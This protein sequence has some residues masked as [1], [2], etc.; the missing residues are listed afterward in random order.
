MRKLGVALLVSFLFIVGGASGALADSTSDYNKKVADAK[1]V[2]ATVEANL[3]NAKQVLENLKASSAT[4]S[5]LL[6]D[7][8]TAVFNADQALQSARETYLSKR[9]LYDAAVVAE[10]NAVDAVNLAVDAVAVAADAVDSSYQTY[11]EASQA[12][13]SADSELTTAQWNYD[14][15][16]ITSG[17][18]QTTPGLR[19]EVYTGVDSLG[20]P[21]QRSQSAYT[22]CKT[23]TVTQIDFNVGGGSVAGCGNDFVMIH[24]TGYITYPTAKSV[25]FYAQADDGF[26]LTINGQPI[27]ND[28]SLKGCGGNSA[29]LFTFQAGVSYP[30]DAW[31]YEWGGGAC[32][33]LFHQPAGSGVWSITPASM[34]TQQAVAVSTKDPALKLILDQKTAA[35]VSAV[36]VEETAYDAYLVAESVYDNAV[37]DYESKLA[38]L[39][40]KR[41][42]LVSAET[43]MNDS[44]NVWQSASDAYID[45]DAVLTNRKNQ[46]KVVFDQ[47]Q[48]QALVID[49]L[50]ND[51]VTAKANLAAIPKPVAPNKVTKKTVSKP[52]ATTK[53]VPKVT[54]TPIPKK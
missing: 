31:F 23:M 36:A 6:A 49:G 41:S 3:A 16:L 37:T 1:Q 27:I 18:T 45:A 53:A 13:A 34:F 43:V 39:N 52:S 38:V 10:N 33:T 30:I 19:A 11:D 22:L 48:S 46:F 26:Y 5:G 15:N 50:E 7:A 4:E 42:E 21:P 2:I 29:G 54:F 9:D 17:S 25:Y 44:E 35:Y 12:V 28:W 47:L 40:D 8:Q 20:N 51:L 14:N 32:A 24:Y